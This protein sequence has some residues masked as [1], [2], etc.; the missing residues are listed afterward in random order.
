MRSHGHTGADGQPRQHYNL[1]FAILALGGGTYAVLQSLVAPALPAIQRDLHVSAA[2]VS[3]I[4]SAYLLSASVLTPIIGRLGDMFGKERTLVAVL[5][6]LALG[7]LVA[8]LA[9]SLPLLLLGRVIQGAGGAIFPL[10]FG[11]I[12]DEFPRERVPQGIAMMSAIIGIGGGLGIVL[13]GPI[14]N[15]FNYHW[16][17]WFPLVLVVIATVATVF[18]IPE[19]PIM[20]PGRV[21]WAGA[22]LLSAWLVCVLV[23]ISQGSTWGWG[24]PR[25]LG[26]L[27][28][29]GLL[30]VA[31][32]RNELRAAEP[33][34]DMDMMRIRGVWTVNAAA[35]LVG[36]G[37]YSS[38]ILI[39]EFVEMPKSVGFGF[40]AS[41]T[42][43][44]LFLLP[45]TVG[46]LI[47]SPL[48]GRMASRVGARVPL[49][50]G[51]AVTTVSFL[52]LAVAHSQPWEIYV[53]AALLGTGIGFAF[54]SLANLIV[55]AVRPEQTG[56]ATGV[57]TVMRSLG[58]AVGATI[59]AS[60][61][62][63]T[64]TVTGLPSER[65]FTLAFAIAAAECALAMVASLIVPRPSRPGDAPAAVAGSVEAA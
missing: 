59:G 15:A 47:V 64:L 35:F 38:F 22:A 54:A 16:L 34:V 13:A 21:N 50:L 48:A 18:F 56:V 42:G 1:T 51:C 24:D 19:S 31:W 11:I 40:A 63:A 45:A 10:G 8:A 4:L 29:G 30:A 44:G 36:A 37:M 7:T 43:A 14:V 60:V 32:V 65:G 52:I 57:N 41:I 28:A 33:L 25:V 17:F 20:S 61:L 9:T 46:M 23:A 53:A 26:L 62:T 27:V 49:V 5:V 6:A 58:G 55:E 39:P 2:S 3:W 12:R